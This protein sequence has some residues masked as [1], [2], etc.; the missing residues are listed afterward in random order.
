M[1]LAALLTPPR[2][3]PAAA[4]VGATLRS[5]P[6]LACAGVVKG[7]DDRVDLATA[8]ASPDREPREVPVAPLHACVPRN[9]P[10][11]HGAKPFSLH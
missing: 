1:L 4:V 6:P 5:I 8:T 2:P 3:R 9:S 10:A 7:P 11:E